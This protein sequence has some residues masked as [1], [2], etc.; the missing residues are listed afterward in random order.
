[1]SDFTTELSA[2]VYDDKLGAF[3]QIGEDAD[4]LDLC[5]IAYSDGDP[6]E[7]GTPIVIPWPMAVKVALAILKLDETRADL[8]D[9]E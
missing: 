4:A 6:A 2:R 8:K 7:M 9:P 5:E 1:M 3:V